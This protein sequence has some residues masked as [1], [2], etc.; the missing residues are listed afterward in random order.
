LNFLKLKR[1]KIHTFAPASVANVGCG[2]D[3]FGFALHYPGDEV[4]LKATDSPGITITN[5]SGDG[6]LLSKDVKENTAGVSLQA[7]MDYLH[8]DF[9]IEMEIYKKMPIGS[10][11]G[12]SAASSVASVYA[13][14]Q[15]LW[16]PLDKRQLLKFAIAGEKIASGDN[17]HLDNITACLYGGFILVRSKNPVDVVQIPTPVGLH[18]AVLHPQIEIKTEASRK[19]LRKQITL[20]QAVTQWGNVAGTVTALF[21]SDFEL[22]KRSLDDVVVVPDR[23]E[24]IPRYYQIYEAA[25][26]AGAIGCS[27]SGSGPSVFALGDSES[28]A[29]KIGKAMTDVLNGLDIGSDLY[30]SAIN[31]DGPKVME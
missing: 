15:M 22:L 1:D 7:M 29:K 23:A 5:I 18:C 3:I 13:L 14:N 9:G 30:I 26:S 11:L 8:A 25:M 20:E 4:Y 16:K 31:N 10:G 19:L 12:S 28:S 27:I 6:N 17:I 24:L 2:F 21:T